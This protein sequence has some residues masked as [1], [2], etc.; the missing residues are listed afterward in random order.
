MLPCVWTRLRWLALG[1]S[2]ASALGAGGCDA[3]LVVGCSDGVC[4]DPATLTGGS[5]GSGGAPECL[6]CLPDTGLQTGDFP[7]EIETIIQDKC[8]RCHQDPPL[9]GAPF[10]LLT[11]EN[12]QADYVK[13]HIYE[14]MA[15][16]IETNFMPLTPP[17]LDAAEKET[18][19]A[20]LCAC[21]PPAAPGEACEP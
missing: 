1:L 2:A 7:C 17:K 21:A 12:T 20:W 5:G 11:Y 6:A 8:Q 15:K 16:A 18:M 3:E 9:K 14:R 13:K 19:L 4:I 10:P